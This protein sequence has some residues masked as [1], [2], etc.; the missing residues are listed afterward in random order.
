MKSPG[1]FVCLDGIE[2]AGKSTHLP[3]LIDWLKEQGIP[4]RATREPGGTRL[5]EWV[6][7]ILLSEQAPDS[8]DAELLLLFAARAEH[9]ETVIKP[10]LARG[11]WVVSDRFLD[12]SYA[13][14]GAG[15]Q[16]GVERV[17]ALANWL[18]GDWRPDRVLVLD[19][20][21]EVAMERVRSRGNGED[22]YERQDE[23]FFNRVRECYLQRAKA[24]PQRY[25]VI[26]ARQ[27]VDEVNQQLQEI[28]QQ[29]L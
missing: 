24:E 26:D 15:W 11:E 19:V 27:S 29:M 5:G 3:V 22:R 13:Y 18:L 6:R 17:D 8:A 20:P 28:L 10:A 14:Q 21:A 23:Q 9:V 7:E 25:C 2:G 1:K 16:L 12:A 4:C